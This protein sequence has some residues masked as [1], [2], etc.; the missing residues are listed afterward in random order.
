MS[1][2]KGGSGHSSPTPDLK[3]ACQLVLSGSGF[4]N[5]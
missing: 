2:A 3:T 5:Y 1:T 4:G